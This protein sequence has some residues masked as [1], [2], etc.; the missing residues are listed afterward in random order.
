M[1]ISIVLT[2]AH[3]TAHKAYIKVFK[4]CWRSWKFKL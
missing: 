4:Y 2:I 1:V 3:F